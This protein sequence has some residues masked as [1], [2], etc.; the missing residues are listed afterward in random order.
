MLN[1][2]ASPAVSVQ[3]Q[4]SQALMADLLL[5]NGAQSRLNARIIVYTFL[6][7]CLIL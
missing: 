6:Q 2:S 7:K 4:Y 5:D 3:K 1:L